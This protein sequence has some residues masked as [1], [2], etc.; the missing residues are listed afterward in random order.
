MYLE[1]I[2]FRNNYSKLTCHPVV[3]AASEPGNFGSTT[4]CSGIND[5]KYHNTANKDSA[6][7]SYFGRKD[8]VKSRNNDSSE[9]THLDLLTI[10]HLPHNSNAGEPK[11][12]TKSTPMFAATF[13][14]SQQMYH[15]PGQP[16]CVSCVRFSSTAAVLNPAIAATSQPCSS[17][18]GLTCQICLQSCRG[19]STLVC[20]NCSVDI[21]SVN[22]YRAEMFV[23]CLGCRDRFEDSGD[24]SM[25]IV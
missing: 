7:T 20:G 3:R 12:P 19:C 6:I 5:Q 14:N 1:L 15:Q 18:S 13:S 8:D 23:A 10:K 17:C 11:K 24:C 16:V 4:Y 22:G 2:Y 21:E 9:E 25:D